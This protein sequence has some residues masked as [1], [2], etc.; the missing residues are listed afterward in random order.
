MEDYLVRV[1]AKDAGVRGFACW[2]TNLVN[3]AAQR[4]ETQPTAT[5]VLGEGLIAGVLLGALLKVQQRVAIKFEGN[6]PIGKLVVEGD[7]YGRVRGYVQN[8]DVD[9][10]FKL[11]EADTAAAIGDLGAMVVIKDLRLKDLYEGVVPLENGDIGRE[12]NFY[13]NQSEQIPSAVQ[14]GLRLDEQGQVTAAGGLLLQALPPYEIEMVRQ[15]TDRVEE[16][17]PVAELLHSGQTPEDLL[18]QIFAGIEFEILEKRPL[19]FQC[20]CSWERTRHALI[21]L[22]QEEIEHLLQTE[23]QAEVDCH[24]CHNQYHFSADDLQLILLELDE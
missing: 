5:A 21:T 17:P 3:E 12:L 23:G 4:H 6:G 18:A 1:I 10:P 8:P 2:T 19:S 11:G 9:L 15:L 13:L 22:G 14:I 16:M 24:Y 7:S 20:D